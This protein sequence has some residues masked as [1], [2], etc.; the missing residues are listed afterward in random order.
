MAVYNLNRDMNTAAE[1]GVDTKLW[2]RSG[3]RCRTQIS[4]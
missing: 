2:Y 3:L 4:I 1:R